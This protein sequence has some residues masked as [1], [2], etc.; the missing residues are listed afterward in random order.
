MKK[1]QYNYISAPLENE[2]QLQTSVLL[3]T[4]NKSTSAPLGNDSTSVPLGNDSTS[5]PLGNDSTS[6]PLGNDLLG[7][8][9]QII[10]TQSDSDA[11]SSEVRDEMQVLYCNYSPVLI[12]NIFLFSGK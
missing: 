7:N 3:A 5:A 10:V 1:I 11:N 2:P 6:V 8:D 12:Y 9:Y 4:G